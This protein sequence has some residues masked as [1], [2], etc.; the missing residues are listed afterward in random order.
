MPRRCPRCPGA[1]AALSRC[2]RQPSTA[3]PVFTHYDPDDRIQEQLLAASP[4][5]AQTL[6]T[7]HGGS[8]VQ[9]QVCRLLI[10]QSEPYGQ[11]HWLEP[12]T[13]TN[14]GEGCLA[15][16]LTIMMTGLV[17]IFL[18]RA[19]YR[20][21]LSDSLMLDLAGE[22]HAICKRTK[23][24]S[25]LRHCQAEEQYFDAFAENKGLLQNSQQF[26]RLFTKEP[27]N[28][29]EFWSNYGKAV[30]WVGSR[31]YHEGDAVAGEAVG[32]QLGQLGVSVRNMPLLA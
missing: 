9:N 22:M 26:T 1:A 25:V 14:V 31:A 19:A 28:G 12:P 23:G 30:G 16:P 24:I 13:T 2:V 3:C 10:G 5:S 4:G 21:V 32:Q 29:L 6:R 17:R 11:P 7:T 20:S 27:D 8:S 18:A 15:P